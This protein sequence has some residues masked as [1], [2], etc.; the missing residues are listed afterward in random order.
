MRLLLLHIIIFVFIATNLGAQ[1]NSQAHVRVIRTNLLDAFEQQGLVKRPDSISNLWLWLDGD[2]TT[3][4]HT[5][6]ACSSPITA[7]NDKVGCWQDKSGNGFDFVQTKAADRP[8]V[9]LDTIN[10]RV[11]AVNFVEASKDFLESPLAAP[12]HLTNTDMTFFMVFR[13]NKLAQKNNAALFSS[14]DANNIGGTWEMD[15]K[16]TDTK[17]HHTAR[18]SGGGS[19]VALFDSNVL[20]LKLYTF[21]YEFSAQD[22]VTYVDGTQEGSSVLDIIQ[23]E[24][25]KL[26]VNRQ[27]STFCDAMI[28][29]VIIYDRKLSVCEINEIILYLSIKYDQSSF[30]PIPVPGGVDCSELFFWLRTDV[31]TSTTVDGTPLT[32][33]QDKAFSN[34]SLVQSSAARQPIYR[35]NATDN[36]NFHPVIDFDGVNDVLADASV[37]GGTNDRLTVYIVAQEDVRQN[38]EILALK[39]SSSI[40]DRVLMQSPNGAGNIVWDAGT[41]AAPN[42]TVGAATY[43]VLQP[44]I[45]RFEN[46][47]ITGTEQ[48]IYIDGTFVG[49]DLSASSLSGMD[50]TILG[51]LINYY[52]GKIPEILIYETTFSAVQLNNLDTYLAIKY[53]ITLGHDYFDTDTNLIYDVSNGYANG[54]FGV[55]LD[56]LTALNQPKSKSEVIGEAVTFELTTKIA[57]RQFLISG[58]NG[59]GFARVTLNGDPNV[60]TQKWFADMTGDVGTVNVELDL[61]NVGANPAAAPANVKIVVANNPAFVNPYF[62]EAT[63]VVGGIAYFQGIPLY[64]KYYTFSA[65]P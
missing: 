14:A 18:P 15:Y 33:W 26:G 12:D 65:A 40:A 31:G 20:D 51:G 28:S 63:S 10:G 36:I 54:I 16:G 52:D 58:H 27:G 30:E 53:G 64:D 43:P 47:A 9:L 61:A 17:F 46:N 35:D 21:T 49:D 42:R 3:T 13:A 56:L 41:G 44:S 32:G 55:G 29:E 23:T 5:T 6:S 4:M 45:T 19:V 59:A 1:N 37:I 48:S 39:S 34:N 25:M 8:E 57:D 22:I 24:Y 60:L 38:N 2:D 11:H 62:I 7:N 50:S